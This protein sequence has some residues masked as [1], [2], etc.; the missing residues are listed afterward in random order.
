MSTTFVISDTHF[1]HKNILEFE[2]EHRPY[3]SLEEMNEALVDNWNKV[4][5]HS[6]VVWHLGDVL[7]GREHFFILDRLHGR[8]NLVLGNHDHYGLANYLEKFRDVQASKKFDGYLLSHIPVHPCQFPRFNGNV[9]GHMHSKI[10]TLPNG[11]PDTR[12]T[13]VSVEH[14]N[15]TPISW[16]DAKGRFG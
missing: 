9:H 5:G 12:Y 1:F 3:S 13:C 2:K 7:F 10:V 11:Q 16:E 4:V 8:K 14:T 6:D 15:M